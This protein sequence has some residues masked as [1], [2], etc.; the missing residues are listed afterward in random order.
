MKC[1]AQTY[2]HTPTHI[3]TYTYTNENVLARNNSGVNKALIVIISSGI[4]FCIFVFHSFLKCVFL[5]LVFFLNL[6]LIML[7]FIEH[8]LSIY[9]HIRTSEHTSFG[10]LFP[11]S[12]PR[13]Y[14]GGNLLG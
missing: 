14:F 5:S 10:L 8:L 7:L 9:E 4:N 2:T 13:L 12:G 6:Y 1:V 3:C 11:Y